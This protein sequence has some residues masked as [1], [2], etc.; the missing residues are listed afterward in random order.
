M[1]SFLKNSFF[2]LFLS[3]VSSLLLSA[4]DCEKKPVQDSIVVYTFMLEDC[5]LTQ[6]YTLAFRQLYESYAPYDIDFIGLFPNIFST[7][8]KIDSFQ[9][10]YKLPF[11]LKTDHSQTQTQLFGA[12]VTPE[13]VVYN[14]TKEHILYKGRIDNAYY[15][16]GRR[17]G[18]T[19][20]FDLKNALEALVCGKEIEV[21]ETEAV[22]CFINLRKY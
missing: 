1:V 3:G 19:N 18:V 13:V 9:Q 15:R 5:L 20:S 4:Q 8:E 7:D 14:H 22:G 12:T 6:N 21:K 2:L 10:T 16:V 11:L 17:R